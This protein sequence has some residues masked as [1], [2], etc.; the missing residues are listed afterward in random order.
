GNG[1]SMT[2]VQ[3]GRSVETSL[4]MTPLEG[5][6]MGTRCGDIDPALHAILHRSRGMD[7]EEIDAMLNRESGLKG[8]CGMN[9]MRDIHA[10]RQQGDR[11]AKL[12]FDMFV[13]RIR[14]YIGAYFAVLGRVDA[15]VF[16]AGI[17]END[18]EVRKAALA[19]LENLGIIL[20]HEANGRRPGDWLR[21]SA[22]ESKV[23]LLVV[24]TNEELEI[25]R[26]TVEVLG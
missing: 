21:I 15:L 26:Q 13:H 4:G 24:R 7:I 22:P 19:G 1:C 10:A 6:I 5:L 11:L 14:K 23:E 18:R 3:N 2:A 12:A 17:G 25:A 9:D 8:V 20:D 16:T